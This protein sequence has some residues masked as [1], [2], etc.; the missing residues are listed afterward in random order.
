MK[1]WILA[2]A[3]I[4]ACGTSYAGNSNGCQGNCPSDGGGG[5]TATGG[6]AT[7]G[8]G[9][10]GNGYGGSGGDATAVGV[11]VGVGLGGQGGSGGAGGRGGD[12]GNAIGL[13]GAGGSVSGSGNSA[14]LNKN[15]ATAISGSVSGAD[16]SSS[17]VSGSQSGAT[18][19][20]GG[21]SIT[22]GPTTVGGQAASNT[23]TTNVSY[24]TERNAPP[25][26]LGQLTATMSCS[27]SFNAG[28]SSQG[29]SGAFGFT[30]ISGDCRSVVTADKFRELGM[31]DTSCKILKTTKG[32]KR[33]AK[34]NPE[35]T[36]I[37]CTAK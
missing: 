4:V 3:L 27:G 12:G 37:D 16:S 5:A 11:G 25:V 22:N 36:N 1:K 31:V 26:Y 19:N 30:W 6:N 24:R 20:S 17:A 2:A 9:Y 8:N 7:G 34:A 29:G 23:S 13:G 18:S 21:N 32:F 28:S 35:L 33:A 15:D 14:N 10:G